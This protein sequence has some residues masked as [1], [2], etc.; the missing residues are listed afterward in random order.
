MARK[1][2]LA[3]VIQGFPPDALRRIILTASGGAFRDWPA[4]DLVK[5]RSPRA[6]KRSLSTGAA[7]DQRHRD[8]HDIVMFFLF[9]YSRYLFTSLTSKCPEGRRVGIQRTSFMFYNLSRRETLRV[10]TSSDWGGRYTPHLTI[11]PG[12]RHV[13]PR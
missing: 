6:G 11:S 4:A 9:S 5:V 12:I 13:G 1:A 3:P 10:L 7:A 8:T 2:A